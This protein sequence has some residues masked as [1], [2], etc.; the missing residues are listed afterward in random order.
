MEPIKAA[1]GCIG[2][3]HFVVK[4]H[5][6]V[7]EMQATTLNRSEGIRVPS[8]LYER[9]RIGLE[10]QY[11]VIECDDHRGPYKVSTRAYMFDI[12]SD[13]RADI[14]N[15]HW[16]PLTID[17]SDVKPH[18][19]IGQAFIPQVGT[20]HVPTRRVAA[21]EVLIMAVDIMAVDAFG[22]E[23]KVAEWR[24]IMEQSLAVHIEHREWDE[25]GDAPET[26]PA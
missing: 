23:P 7:G 6:E 22:V 25:W 1:V 4:S 20:L 15:F 24:S 8:V 9:L 10:I 2:S 5:P 26:F 18:L 21:E 3:G 11:V 17:G 19:H 12:Q 16:H 14:I 13:E